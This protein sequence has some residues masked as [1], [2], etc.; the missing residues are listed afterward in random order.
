MYYVLENCLECILNILT[1]PHPH[2]PTHVTMR[3]DGCVNWP[4]SGNHFAIYRCCSVLQSSPTLCTHQACNIYIYH[5]GILQPLNLPFVI[6]QLYLT[7][8]GGKKVSSYQNT[9]EFVL[10]CNAGALGGYLLSW[11][12]S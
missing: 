1:A 10:N 5:I 9:D 2:C 4:Y 3:G 6:C 11:I 12:L 8:A 7:K